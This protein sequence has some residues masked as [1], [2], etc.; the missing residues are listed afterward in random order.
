MTVE[1]GFIG[2]DGFIVFET[3]KPPVI[4]PAQAMEQ[5]AHPTRHVPRTTKGT[6]AFEAHQPNRLIWS[7]AKREA[8]NSPA[9]PWCPYCDKMISRRDRRQRH[10]DTAHSHEL[11][12][13]SAQL[14]PDHPAIGPIERVRPAQSV[15]LSPCP[16]CNANV[17]PDRMQKHALKVHSSTT[18]AGEENTPNPTKRF[19]M[20]NRA[21]V[22]SRRAQLHIASDDPLMSACSLCGIAVRGNRLQRHTTKV[23]G[24][25]VP[26]QPSAPGARRRS[27]KHRSTAP[28]RL[29]PSTVPWSP[30][31]S[32]LD[33]S[34][35]LGYQ[36]RESDGRFGSFPM[37]D[38]YSDSSGPDGRR[39]SDY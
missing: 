21:S 35:G 39:D 31:E 4:I 14:H 16:Q 5:T 10:L 7:D 6:E 13:L 18:A 15:S 32:D 22:E 17:R 8:L 38:D 3:P 23:H 11:A 28:E 30:S 37:H 1:R 33:G 2:P 19:I 24:A 34:Y 9:W 29:A 36:R 26:Q 12:L 27:G 25:T 20:V